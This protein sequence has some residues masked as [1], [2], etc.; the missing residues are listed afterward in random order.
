MNL[1]CLQCGP[2]VCND[3][4]VLSEELFDRIGLD[5]RVTNFFL[6]A[7][8]DELMSH[9][10]GLVH[11]LLD[12]FLV[13]V[14]L[15]SVLEGFDSHRRQASSVHLAILEYLLSIPCQLILSFLLLILAL[16]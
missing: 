13:E 6:H 10:D 8:L 9:I 12:D 2:L 5:A 15:E 16:D 7:A 14:N 4:F 11:T 3:V 1:C